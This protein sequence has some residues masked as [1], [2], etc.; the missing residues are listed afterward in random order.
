MKPNCSL[1]RVNICLHRINDIF[2]HNIS[3]Y[4]YPD[5]N[6]VLSYLENWCFMHLNHTFHSEIEPTLLVFKFVNRHEAIRFKLI[7]A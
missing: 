2:D 7:W 3:G 6:N 5:Q 4:S 1:Y